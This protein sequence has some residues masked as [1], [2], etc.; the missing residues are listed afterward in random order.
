MIKRIALSIAKAALAALA[1]GLLG[2]ACQA[3]VPPAQPVTPAPTVNYVD[4]IYFPIM[5]PADAIPIA[6]GRGRF[7]LRDGCIWIEYARPGTSE[8]RVLA[9]WPA[10]AR[11]RTDAG[12]V[13]IS[14][15][16]GQWTAT[17]GD[18]YWY[19]GGETKDL[20]YVAELTGAVPPVA[21]RS[22]VYWRIYRLSDTPE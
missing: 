14:D 22:D 19:V 12:R 6:A 20:S 5:K 7:V 15:V 3:S 11:L 16:G 4:G 17:V 9:L 10:G 13:Q 18:V 2:S 8:E 1:I 21:C